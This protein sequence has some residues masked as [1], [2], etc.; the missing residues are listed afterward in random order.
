VEA[1]PRP[2]KDES[3]AELGFTPRPMVRWFDPVQLAGTALQVV[4]SALFGAYADKRELQAA[5]APEAAVRHDYAAGEELWVDYVADLG[6]GFP[7]TYTVAHVL[8]RPEL[9]LDGEGGPYET[10]RGRL[11]VMGGD[12]VYPTATRVAYQDRMLGVYRAALPCAPEGD[13]PH[14]YVIPGNH[15]WY[16][17][18]T[19]FIRSFCQK[20]WIGGW[21]TQQERS[22]FALELP[23]RWWLWAIDIQFDAYVDDPQLDYFRR[24]RELLREGDCVVLVTGKPSWTKAPERDPSYE[25]L[26]FFE[27]ELLGGTGAELAV[28]LSGDLHHYARYA[29]SGGRQR[30]TSGGGGAYLYPTHHLPETLRLEEVAGTF[31]YDLAA[32]YPP[33][34]V[35]RGLRWRAIWRLPLRNPRFLVVVAVLYAVPALLLEAAASRGADGLGSTWV[36]TVASRE[37]AFAAMVLL[38]VFLAFSAAKGLRRLLI[39]GLHASAHLL[40]VSWLVAIATWVV[41]ESWSDLHGW[42]VVLVAAMVGGAPGAALVGLY[43]VLCDLA[44]GE[45]PGGHA[46]ECFSCQAIDGWKGFLRLHVGADGDLTIYPV[47][48]D[49]VPPRRR[50]RLEPDAAP[51]EPF[52]SLPDDV[53]PRLIEPPI[54]IPRPARPAP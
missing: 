36:D 23:H 34:P 50:I 33:R 35:S 18:L 10:R 19:S 28:V 40:L 17:G 25:N 39:G 11:L 26:E 9:T 42:A 5:L 14:L 29:G 44:L 32:V 45:K 47:G 46:N 27:R 38:P 13:A 43:L 7:S 41:P 48:I 2:P 51:G 8:A 12:E 1:A 15:D 6:D 20:R 52:F 30:I 4:V 3:R 31:D 49:E 22:Y 16:D 21:K 24:A 37:L 53:R 54:R